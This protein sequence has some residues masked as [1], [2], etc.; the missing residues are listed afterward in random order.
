MFSYRELSRMGTADVYLTNC[1]ADGLSVRLLTMSDSL[2]LV[3]SLLVATP[4]I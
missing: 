2:T 3:A 1:L 4:A